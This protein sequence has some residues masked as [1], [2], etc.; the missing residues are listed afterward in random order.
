MVDTEKAITFVLVNLKPV[1]MSLMMDAEKTITSVVVNPKCSKSL[2]M[3]HE[4]AL[5]L[6][7]PL[8]WRDNLVGV[9]AASILVY[10]AEEAVP[11]VPCHDQR[12]VYQ[13]SQPGLVEATCLF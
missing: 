10:S 13:V 1:I 9:D 7:F 2:L 5:L 12:A 4:P 11:G 8:F 6:L 3:L